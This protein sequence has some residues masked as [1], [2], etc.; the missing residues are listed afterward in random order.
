MSTT[1]PTGSRLSAE[2][3]SQL[4]AKA[5]TVANERVGRQPRHRPL[6][7]AIGAYVAIGVLPWL[8]L[9]ATGRP[10]GELDLP[11]VT[12]G[13]A[14]AV[15]IYFWQRRRLQRWHAAQRAAYEELVA[16]ARRDT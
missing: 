5:D 15:A 7:L 13:I 2:K 14:A 11:L 3:A 8:V 1:S 10:P 6:H 12:V 4:D 9:S 16:A